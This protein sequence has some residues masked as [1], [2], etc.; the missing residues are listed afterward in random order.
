VADAIQSVARQAARRLLLARVCESAAVWAA[1][2]GLVS[3]AMQACA[4]VTSAGPSWYFGLPLVVVI[5]GA[6]FGVLQA[7]L[8]GVTSIEAAAVVDGQRDLAERFATAVELTTAGRADSPA[9]RACREQAMAALGEAPLAGVSFWRRTVRTAAALGLVLIVCMT[10]AV[11]GE[12]RRA[13]RRS[14]GGMGGNRRQQL[15]AELRRGAAGASREEIRRALD[16]AAL[17]VEVVDDDELR[18]LLDE[19]RAN[20]LELVELTPAEVRRVLGLAEEQLPGAGENGQTPA[21]GAAL[22]ESIVAGELT[23]G[24]TVYDPLFDGSVEGTEGLAGSVP[25]VDYTVPYADAWKRAR[26]RAMASLETGEVPP[27]YRDIIRSYFAER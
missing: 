22:D 18:R 15:A 1:A 12:M 16:S 25:K 21:E 7:L 10:L 9:G 2:A 8:R 20:G 19:L 4:L 24:V 23:G 14:L 11:A 3:A 6:I 5:A 17:A 27:G 26:Q 13:G